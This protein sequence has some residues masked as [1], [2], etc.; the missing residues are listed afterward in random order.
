MSKIAVIAGGG[1]NL[2]ALISK[3][4]AKDGYSIVVHYNSE[5]S[6]AESEATIKEIISAGGNA[7]G[8]Q[9][10]LTK[11]D[12]IGK[13]FAI[14]KSKGKITVAIN[15]A[16]KVLKKPILD[17]T[18]KEYD[19]MFNVNSK[20]SFFFIQ[21]ALKNIE[22]GGSIITIVT[23]LLAAYTPLY[24]TYQGSKAPVDYF[25]KA[26]SKEAMS[27]NILVNA[28]AP[29]PMDTPFFYAQE[30]EDAIAFHKSSAAQ[31]RLTKIEDIVPIVDLLVKGQHWINGQT[32]YSNGGYTSKT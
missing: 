26:A 6:K 21:H 18:E 29:G 8:F 3:S 1:K 31:G 30:T 22:D 23:S 11:V 2:G 17:V 13:L 19:D 5:S 27:R 9:A 12:E 25:T 20:I 7:W 16:G 10:D 28:I 14:A 15:T 32:I 24:S 4:L